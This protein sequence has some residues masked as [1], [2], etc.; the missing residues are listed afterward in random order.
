[1][2]L[3]E[4][5]PG[6]AVASARWKSA[7][8][9]YDAHEGGVGYAEKISEK[10]EEALKLCLGIMDECECESGCPSCVP[11]L[12]PGVNNEELEQFL[13]ESDAALACTRSLL[14]SL[15]DGEVIV[16]DVT[17]IRRALAPPGEPPPEDEEAKKLETRLTK[18]SKIL[19]AKRER[20]H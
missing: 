2:Y 5:Q 15:L 11:P 13:I 18:A 6:D 7:L 1:M 10:M 4:D 3:H 20:L 14:A 17:I 19:K 8:Y 16:P 12:P 9:L